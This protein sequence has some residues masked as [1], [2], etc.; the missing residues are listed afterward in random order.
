[1]LVLFVK[2]IDFAL[3][4]TTIV[5]FSTFCCCWTV[6]ALTSCKETGVN[7]LPAKIVEAMTKLEIYRLF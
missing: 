6:F 5:S 7:V 1:M 3:P 4:S 2:E